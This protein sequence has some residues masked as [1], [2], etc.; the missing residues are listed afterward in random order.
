V[1]QPIALLQ[2]RA[3]ELDAAAKEASKA[4]M[5]ESGAALRNKDAGIRIAIEIVS[6]NSNPAPLTEVECL[7]R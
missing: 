2:A 7:T 6:Q 1:S 5:F 3:A 4:G